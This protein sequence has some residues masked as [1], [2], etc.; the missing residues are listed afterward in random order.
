LA[1]TAVKDV[2]VGG[3]MIVKDG[4]HQDQEEIVRKFQELQKRLWS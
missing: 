2:L 1:R 3:N 4:Q